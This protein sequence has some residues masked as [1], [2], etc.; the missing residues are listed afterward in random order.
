MPKA[1]PT[2]TRRELLSD[3]GSPI[4][5]SVRH[6]DV[7]GKPTGAAARIQ[8]V[9]AKHIST[10]PKEKKQE[11]QDLP[12]PNSLW[13]GRYIS[14]DDIEL[15][16]PSTSKGTAL[17]PP[18][19]PKG[20]PSPDDFVFNTNYDD[21]A[22]FKPMALPSPQLSNTASMG[23]EPYQEFW[24]KCRPFQCHQRRQTTWPQWQTD[25]LPNI[26]PCF[27]KY[28]E[29]LQTRGCVPPLCGSESEAM[30][31]DTM[32]QVKYCDKTLVHHE[33]ICVDR[34]SECIYKLL[35]IY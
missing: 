2:K 22:C 32:C 1:K 23:L 10:K 3:H 34:D 13:R 16:K 24:K 28:E 35:F 25:T 15:E 7:F 21:N 20:T 4:K 19:T 33:V 26:L 31:V 12:L 30:D 5:L 6:T 14:T 11:K 29:I 27:L 18:T 17:E 8:T 9:K